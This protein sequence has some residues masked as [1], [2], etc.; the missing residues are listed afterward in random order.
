[1]DISRSLLL[2]D[3]V[4]RST[5]Y[6]LRSSHVGFYRVRPVRLIRI[7]VRMRPSFLSICRVCHHAERTGYGA[8]VVR[9]RRNNAKKKWPSDWELSFQTFQFSDPVSLYRCMHTH[10]VLY[11]ST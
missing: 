8:Y 9:R 4:I 2:G 3:D 11:R 5:V 1:M 6:G 10:C 7:S